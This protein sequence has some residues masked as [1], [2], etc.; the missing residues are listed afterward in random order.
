MTSNAPSFDPLR[1][2]PEED[3]DM[4]AGYLAAGASAPKPRIT[5]VAF[6]HGWRIRKNDRAGVID[7]DQHELA[8]RYREQQETRGR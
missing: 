3:S 2:T 5:S 1:P 8:R 7:D 4:V 6:D